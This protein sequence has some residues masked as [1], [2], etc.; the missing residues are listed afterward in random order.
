MKRIVSFGLVAIVGASL[1]CSDSA[2]DA[3]PKNTNP[4]AVSRVHRATDGGA[5]G[6][7]AANPGAG[8]SSGALKE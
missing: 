1:G 8:K 5:D 4:N 3:Q 6:G 7:G 2:K